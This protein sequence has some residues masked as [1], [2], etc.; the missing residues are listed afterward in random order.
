[1]LQQPARLEV[2]G[3]VK[4]SVNQRSRRE[5]FGKLFL[6]DDGDYEWITVFHPDRSKLRM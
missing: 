3:K 2:K 5:A 6:D 1:V 4:I